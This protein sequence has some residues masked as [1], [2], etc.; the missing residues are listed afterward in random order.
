MKPRK[1]NK[2]DSNKWDRSNRI[3]ENPLKRRKRSKA[4]YKYKNHWL[5]EDDSFEFPNY[6][7]EEE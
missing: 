6:K 1:E 4:K 2:K 5:E 7:I 3:D